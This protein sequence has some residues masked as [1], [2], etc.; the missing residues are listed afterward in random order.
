MERAHF[1]RRRDE[2]LA[3]AEAERKIF[4]N[5]DANWSYS[6]SEG[7]VDEVEEEA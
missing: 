7:S 2:H 6:S 1:Q 4:V 5:E 3:E